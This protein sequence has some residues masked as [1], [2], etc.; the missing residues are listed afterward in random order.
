MNFELLKNGFPP[1]VIKKEDRLNYYEC[2]DKAH[3]SEDYSDFIEMI[4]KLEEE[5]LDFYL[6][7]IER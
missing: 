1:V 2:S 4:G 5:M 3:I 7:L 6:K